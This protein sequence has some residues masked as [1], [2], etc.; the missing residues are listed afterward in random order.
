MSSIWNEV[1]TYVTFKCGRQMW[2]WQKT[3]FSATNPCPGDSFD[4]YWIT[5]Y[6]EDE[7]L[8]IVKVLW[9]DHMT[10][11]QDL[12]FTTRSMFSY[13][14]GLFLGNVDFYYRDKSIIVNVRCLCDV[15]YSTEMGQCTTEV[16]AGRLSAGAWSIILINAQSGEYALN[17]RNGNFKGFY[18]AIAT[19]KKKLKC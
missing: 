7:C 4:S 16:S 14:P 13:V 11:S 19:V 10:E 8:P 17:E 12:V 9:T 1:S 3:V 15:T 6:S 5:I 18:F 2:C